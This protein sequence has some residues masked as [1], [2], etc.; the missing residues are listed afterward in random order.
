[1]IAPDRVELIR[2]SN[3]LTGLDFLQVSPNQLELL[4]FV[5]H[6]A[7]PAV[8]EAALGTIAPNQVEIR[9]VGATAPVTVAVTQHVLPMA[10]LNGRRALRFT[11]AAP[12]G[13]G[14]Y[15]LRITH[16]AIDTYFNDLR[17]T[18]K[19]S[20]PTELDCKAT[21]HDCPPEERVDFP[22]DYRARDFWSFRQALIDFA[23]ARYPDWQDRLEADI[24]MVIVELLS[25]LGDEFAY[26]DDR[27]AREHR[28]DQASQRRS[29]RHLAA[30]VDYPLDNGSG[31]FAWIDVEANGPGALNAGTGVTDARD[32]VVFELGRGLPDTGK[33]FAVSNTRNTFLPY[34]WDENDVCLP[35]GHREL[36][37]IGNHAAAFLPDLAID[38]VGK[39]VLLETV[40]TDPQKPERRLAVR[41]IN[42]TDT[43][44]PLNGNPITEIV[45]DQG[46]VFEMDLETL[47]VR[48]NLVPATSGLTVQKT[49]RIGPPPAGVT[50]DRTIERVGPNHDL[51]DLPD[52]SVDEDEFD[53]PPLA[54]RVN[55]LYPLEG[56]DAMPLVWLPALDGGMRP[57]VQLTL[58]GGTDWAW[59]PALIGAE[60]A[61]VTDEAFT[62]ED[63]MYRRVFGVDR[64][65][66]RF[67]FADYASSLGS[68]IRFGDGEFGIAPADGH[69]FDVRFRLANGRLLNVAA[70]TLTRFRLAAPAFVD[71]VTNPLPAHGGRDPESDVQIRTN[72]PQAFRRLLF[73]AV[74]PEDYAEI[75]ERLPWVQKAGG[76]LRWTGSWSTMFV[77]PDPRDE[78]GLSR[79]NR[80]ELEV[81][82]DRVR[83]AGRDVRVLDPRYADIDLEIHVCVAPN[84]YIGD[85]KER[86]LVALFGDRDSA[87]F[88]DP[89]NFTFGTPLSRAALM[90]AIQE[91]PGVR[92]VETMKVRRRGSFGWR[93]FDEFALRVGV[94]ELIRV[95]NDKLLPERGAVR[96]VMEGGA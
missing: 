18:F 47:R 5:H 12:G 89:D 24:G 23:A 64:I 36:T 14:Y 33:L 68:T 29:L 44:D 67:E 2:L 70:D 72:A 66:G 76:T 48:G 53:T 92:A 10:T 20:C 84:A 54:R 42:A 58:Q 22:V 50:M 9:A 30:L 35:V 34:L 19:A 6:L 27:I 63:G 39:W 90:A 94:N 61:S 79:A 15:T 74:R 51:T 52:D 13:F 25:A 77:T 7:L 60:V 21:P 65:G 93:P 28:L 37:L 49:F 3:T 69:V 43:V 71:A 82:L 81:H 16:P 17:F 96:L 78:F 40:P 32:Q 56:S 75:A 4:V 80:R 55:H 1:V 57:E 8:L 83:Q 87:G 46:T 91:V 88:F 86:V 11:V 85:V 38:P 41:V 26:G 95:T 62:L 31:A 73:R 45:W 59:L